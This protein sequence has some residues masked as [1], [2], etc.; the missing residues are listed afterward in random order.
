VC[1]VCAYV[2]SQS[3]VGNC[4]KAAKGAAGGGGVR[5][6][7]EINAITKSDEWRRFEWSLHHSAIHC[8]A[9]KWL[10]VMHISKRHMHSIPRKGD[11]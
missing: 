6:K 2:G 10:I 3:A 1:G 8:I 7:T 4:G 5:L 11:E 9:T